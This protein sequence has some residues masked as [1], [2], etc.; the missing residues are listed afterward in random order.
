MNNILLPTQEELLELLTS[1]AARKSDSE[2]AFSLVHR[3]TRYRLAVL[4]SNGFGI[5]K[6]TLICA[7]NLEDLETIKHDIIG[8]HNGSY[9]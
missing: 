7:A 1:G 5:E 4:K 3:G 8:E 9:T 2:I 6:F